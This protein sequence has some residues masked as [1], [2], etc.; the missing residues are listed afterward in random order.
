MWN[1]QTKSVQNIGTY[2]SEVDAARAYDCAA[3]KMHG[4]GYTKRNF[5]DEVV[6]EPVSLGDERRER[7]TS[8]Y[9]GVS[10]KTAASAWVVHLHNPQTKR[11]KHIGSYDSETSAAMAYDCAAVQLHG[12]DWPKR[13]F[14]GELI[15]KPPESRGD[16][17]RRLKASR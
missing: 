11:K 14:P 4:P 10:W 2:T 16:E 15:T 1:P 17:R 3:V 9:N 12:P 5:P 6:T 7:K 13:N 8:R